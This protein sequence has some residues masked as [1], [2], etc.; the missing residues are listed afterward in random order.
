VLVVP[1]L[2]RGVVSIAAGNEHSVVTTRAGG[3]FA[4][5][6]TDLNVPP[7]FKEIVLLGVTVVDVTVEMAEQVGELDTTTL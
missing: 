1:L 2:G 5:G 3:A 6:F 4:V 7:V